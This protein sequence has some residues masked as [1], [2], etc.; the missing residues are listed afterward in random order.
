MAAPPVP[1]WC[2]RVAALDPAVFAE[3]LRLEL[4][5]HP[6]PDLSALLHRRERDGPAWHL[7]VVFVADRPRP[8]KEAEARWPALSRAVDRACL[9]WADVLPAVEVVDPA[10]ARALPGVVPLGPPRPLPPP[11]PPRPRTAGAAPAARPAA[12]QPSPQP[13][14]PAATQRSLF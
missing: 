12:P 8:W 6:A 3:A 9:L 14:P 1:F 7:V 13:P 10:G 5:A 11:P 2:E 4:L